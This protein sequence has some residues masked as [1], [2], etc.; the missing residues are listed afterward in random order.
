MQKIS[1]LDHTPAFVPVVAITIRACRSIVPLDLTAAGTTAGQVA[2]GIAAY[3][4]R[5]DGVT[6]TP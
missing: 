4:R 5:R 1:G 2:E 3:L 6:S